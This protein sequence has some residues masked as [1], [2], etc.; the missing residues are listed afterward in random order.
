MQK[1]A[2]IAASPRVAGLQPQT[3]TGDATWFRRQAPP[4]PAR[5]CG[6]C[7][8]RRGRSFSTP[9]G[10]SVTGLGGPLRQCRG[11]IEALLDAGSNP[12]PVFRPRLRGSIRPW[13]SEPLARP[14]DPEPPHPFR[15]PSARISNPSRGSPSGTSAPLSQELPLPDHIGASP[16]RSLRAARRLLHRSGP[17]KLLVLLRFPSARPPSYRCETVTDRSPGKGRKRR[18]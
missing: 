6:F 14:S 13:S 8:G 11:K 12:I 3:R 17:C 1:G 7:V 5:T 18:K 9:E 2:G 4:A 16:F 10:A 15:G